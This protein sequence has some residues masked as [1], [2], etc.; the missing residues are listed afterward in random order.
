[1]ENKTA[2]NRMFINGKNC[3]L[4]ILKDHQPN[5]LNNPRTR[6][7][8]PEKNEFGRITKSLLDKINLNLRNATKVNQ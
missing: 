6:L 3:C 8:N 5:F 7:L 4:I 1:M 2:L